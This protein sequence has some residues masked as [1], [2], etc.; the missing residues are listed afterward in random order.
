MASFDLE[1]CL[2]YP[3]NSGTVGNY[4]CRLTNLKSERHFKNSAYMYYFT[5]QCTISVS[6]TIPKQSPKIVYGVAATNCPSNSQNNPILMKYRR[7]TR[8]AIY[9]LQE[10]AEKISQYTSENLEP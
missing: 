8:S 3:E 2:E 10:S 1:S 9:P 5:S 7:L 4:T 6:K